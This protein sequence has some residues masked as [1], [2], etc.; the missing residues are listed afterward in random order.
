MFRE[1]QKAQMLSMD[2]MRIGKQM[3]IVVVATPL[4]ITFATRIKSKSEVD[5]GNAV[6][7]QII[8]IESKG[9][10]VER[11]LVQPE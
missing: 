2:I 5:L 4:E 8:Q 3:S 11:I 10:K 1:I 9:F 6:I 7:N